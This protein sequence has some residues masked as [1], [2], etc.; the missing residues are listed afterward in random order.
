MLEF[1]WLGE[2][3]GLNALHVQEEWP[4]GKRVVARGVGMALLSLLVV[5][6]SKRGVEQFGFLR[7]AGD[8]EPDGVFAR[9]SD[10]DTGRLIEL[11]AESSEWVRVPV[12][13]VQHLPR[14]CWCLFEPDDVDLA[15][16]R[17]LARPVVTARMSG[18]DCSGGQDVQHGSGPL[19]EHRAVKPALQGIGVVA[20]DRWPGVRSGLDVE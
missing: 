7:W 10:G 16:L 20:S 8:A 13:C 2:V 12:S 3:A 14:G 19:P 6:L 9:I 11:S 17:S 18:V 15:N 4:D 5:R 1:N